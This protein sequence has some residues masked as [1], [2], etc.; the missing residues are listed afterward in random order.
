[1]R[2]REDRAVSAALQAIEDDLGCS[3]ALSAQER[4]I[5]ANLGRRLK[6]LFKIDTYLD[7]LPSPANRRTRSLWPVV[8]Q[9]HAILDAISKPS[10]FSG[11][12]RPCR[13]WGSTLETITEKRGVSIARNATAAAECKSATSNAAR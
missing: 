12:R 1:M 7:T 2:R 13:H 5:I 3:T 11:A 10:V 9:K 8:L 4:V 6:D